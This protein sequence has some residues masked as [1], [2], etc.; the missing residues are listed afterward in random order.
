L[1]FFCDEEQNED[2]E[3]SAKKDLWQ[4]FNF[5]YVCWCFTIFWLMFFSDEEEDEDED[6]EDSAKKN[7]WQFFNF[8]INFYMYVDVSQFFSWCFFAI[9][10]CML[11]FKIF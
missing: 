2:E 1:M 4:F 3:D 7:L 10:I 5:L 9:F 6:E 11:I 8:F